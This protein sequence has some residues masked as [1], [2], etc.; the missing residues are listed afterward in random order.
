M[1]K[2]LKWCF[3][4][5]AIGTVCA[6]VGLAGIFWYFGQD[7]PQI[8]KRDD[9]NPPQMT[10]IYSADGFVIGEFYTPGS[11][12]T[13]VPE[14]TIPQHVKD[15]F[16]AAEDADFMTHQGIDYLGMV[17]A[18]Y[19]A[20]RYDVG[21]KGTSTITQQVVKNLI[22]SPERNVSR[23]VREIILA[24]ELEKN[25]SK[26]DILYLYLNTI[27]LGHGVNGVEEASRLY[28]G[29]HVSELTLPEGALLAG[30]TQSPEGLTPFRHPEKAMKRRAYVLKQLRDKAFITEAAYHAASQTTL[31]L[32]DRAATD[33]Y[34]GIAPHFVEYVRRE[35]V[36]KYGVE[37]VEGGGLRVETTLNAK[38]QVEAN[39]SL[40]NG[41]RLYDERQK[42]YRPI[43]TLKDTEF[44]KFSTK[45][46][47]QVSRLGFKNGRRFD[48]I[49]TAIDET[50]QHVSVK[51]GDRNAVLELVPRVRVF[52][53]D[54]DKKPIKSVL[55][56]G[57]V[58][59]IEVIDAKREP[60]VV[61]FAPGPEAALVS[62][63]PKTR[64]V[65]AM[66]G[67]FDFEFNKYDH[68]TQAHRQTGSTF[69]PFVYAAALESKQVTPATIFLDS[70][71]V[72]PMD[73][74]K[75]W[76]P[77]NS[78]G[79]WRGPIRVREG[80]GA[81]RNVIAV[82]VL[83]EVGIDKAMD[84]AQR[85]GIESPMVNNFTMV[86]GSSELTPLEITN[87]YATFATGGL[88][89]KPLFITRVTTSRGEKQE[90]LSRSERTIGEDVAWL[91]TSVMR[92]V[93]EGYTDSHGKRRAGTASS[94]A[95]IKRPVA[96]KTGTTN[97]ARDAWFIGFTPQLVTGVWVGF[98]DNRSLGRK[99]YG[100]RVAGPIWLGYMKAA[101]KD[102]PVEEFSAPPL[103]VVSAS[104]D[105]ATG[106]LAREG[107]IEEYFL[108]GTQPTEYAPTADTASSDD[109]LLQQFG[110]SP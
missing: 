27:Y 41:L 55:K 30:L 59:N 70:P 73:G 85:A 13:V 89:A 26:N 44:D 104:I 8:L 52:G 80:L 86:M 60:P 39:K 22:L 72:F 28:F 33:P 45:V 58:V 99:E 95:E 61:R 64:G 109:F 106:K 14:N 110:S 35:L 31:H 43:K 97:E 32:A 7:L 101:L 2:F 68:A 96:G 105:P 50:N 46:A 76:S 49:V 56:R 12:R 93:V 16:M 92:S 36:Q 21:V 63:D 57:N 15:A 75:T 79:D 48:A 6:V 82:R 5:A 71:A 20:V 47:K 54:Y 91:A 9:F 69:K 25:L 102:L 88:S 3:I 10:R 103:G 87:A 4:L 74:G 90:F 34:L 67:G 51:V 18:F 38:R 17:R 83:R 78:D 62:I 29:K 84:F 66:V 37:N 1:K 77:Q 42:L 100:G 107:G 81:S 11:K 24:R 94:L 23:K 19:Y 108:T 53:E 40:Q 98:S 65:V